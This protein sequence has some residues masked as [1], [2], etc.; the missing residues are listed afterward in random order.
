MQV[1]TIYNIITNALLFHVIHI[2]H[3]GIFGT[4]RDILKQ[5]ISMINTIISYELSS[6]TKR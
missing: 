1:D 4:E 5:I 6:T 2:M 3:G